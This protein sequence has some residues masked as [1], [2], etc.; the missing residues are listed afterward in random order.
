MSKEERIIELLEEISK[1]LKKVLSSEEAS[2]G[3]EFYDPK[4][5]LTPQETMKILKVCERTMYNLRESGQIKPVPFGKQLRY[6]A[7]HLFKIRDFHLK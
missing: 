6:F 7:P 3:A 5:W 4:N 2:P 1:D